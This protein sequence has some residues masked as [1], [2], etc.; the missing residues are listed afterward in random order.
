MEGMTSLE[1]GLRR[2]RNGLQGEAEEVM[3]S[4]RVRKGTSR[5]QV[6]FSQDDRWWRS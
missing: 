6:F 2:G 3:T 1:V 4:W 5:L